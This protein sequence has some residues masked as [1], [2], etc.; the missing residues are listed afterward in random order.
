MTHAQV[1]S[2]LEWRVALWHVLHG[3][4]RT[5]P[6]PQPQQTGSLQEE[7]FVF[8]WL[9]LQKAIERLVAALAAVG[10]HVC[11]APEL[12]RLRGIGEQVRCC[13]LLV[14]IGRPSL[15]LFEAGC[16]VGHRRRCG[17]FH[18]SILQCSY[19]CF[20][21]IGRCGALPCQLQ[22]DS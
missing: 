11:D 18:C 1:M 7:A 19:F 5:M 22:F 3:T 17:S 20:S 10:R 13:K 16:C 2:F 15:C 14:H 6:F 8:T 4:H 12:Q 21:M 9:Q